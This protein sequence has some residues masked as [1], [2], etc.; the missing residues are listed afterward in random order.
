MKSFSEL[1]SGE[2]YCY[3]ADK[4][5]TLFR[6]TNTCA[7]EVGMNARRVW[8]QVLAANQT[9]NHQDV[10]VKSSQ[11]PFVHKVP[12]RDITLYVGMNFKTPAFERAVREIT[13]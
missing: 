1:K 2:L 4:I 10:Y 3:K 13:Q 7:H 8:V 12:P 9:Y 11:L 5:E 6:C